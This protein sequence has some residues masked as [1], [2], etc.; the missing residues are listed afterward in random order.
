[1]SMSR[2]EW[3]LIITLYLIVANIMT[4]LI[5]TGV[6]TTSPSTNYTYDLDDTTGKTGIKSN[7]QIF[8]QLMTFSSDIDLG[9][10]I[11]FFLLITFPTIL[12]IILLA[13]MLIPTVNAGS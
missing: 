6:N 11:V 3:F 4:I 10:S 7:A 12:W 9:S 1:M 13:T 2:M 8:F 5:L